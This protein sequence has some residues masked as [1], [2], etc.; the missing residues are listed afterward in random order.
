MGAFG[1]QRLLTSYTGPLLRIRNSATTVETD[2]GYGVD[3]RVDQS[4]ITAAVGGSSAT[5]VKLYDQTGNGRHLTQATTGRQ[6]RIVNAG[7][8]DA[9]G[10][11][12]I[13]RFD[14]VDDCLTTASNLP[15]TNPGMSFLC[16]G[17]IRTNVGTYDVY[18]ESGAG[19]GGT[20][21]LYLYRDASNSRIN[22]QCDSGNFVFLNVTTDR[23]SDNL[24]VLTADRT[25]SGPTNIIKFYKAGAAVT[26]TGSAA[27]S[28][29]GNFT[30]SAVHVGARAGGASLPSALDLKMFA[31]YTLALD[32]TAVSA[33]NTA[34]TA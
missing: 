18:F 28:S 8:I 1:L 32:G 31:I 27:G 26:P 22:A 21:E 23:P 5:V 29:S 19:T 16:Y 30:A 11:R 9:L 13:A 33:I 20:S 24:V 10:G 6:P 15:G 12:V 34:V 7:T 3:N 25:L 14:G 4:A 17:N 2:I